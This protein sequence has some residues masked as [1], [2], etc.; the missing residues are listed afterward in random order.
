MQF[1]LL[2]TSISLLTTCIA[3]STI[4]YTEPG[5]GDISRVRFATNEI[6]HVVIRAYETSNCDGEDE[7]MR[8][9]NGPLIN[10]SPKSL[11][12]PL[13]NYKKNGFKEFNVLAGGEKIIMFVGA[14][15]EG[16]SVAT[17]GVPLSLKFLEKGKDYELFYQF[18]FN[19]CS[20]VSSEIS[21]DSAGQAVK[22]VL[23]IHSNSHDGFGAACLER[24][25]KNRLY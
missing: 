21:R 5:T 16:N 19:S 1:K 22:K 10:S 23:K 6:N 14:A 3:C 12:I 25:K 2:L 4:S 15:A 9:R 11:G 18:N 13:A 8:L 7:W 17:C 20:V 24:F